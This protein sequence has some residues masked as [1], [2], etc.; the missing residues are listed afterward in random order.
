MSQS[1]VQ[2]YALIYLNYRIKFKQQPVLYI[3]F[4]YIYMQDW[5]EL[6][7]FEFIERGMI[8]PLF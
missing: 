2:Y 7:V 1:E 8:N 5:R 4:R 3:L 6:R